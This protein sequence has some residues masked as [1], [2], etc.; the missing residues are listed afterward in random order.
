MRLTIHAGGIIRATL[1]A[2][3]IVAMSGSVSGA[4]F[5]P[6]RATNLKVLPNSIPMDSLVNMMGAFTRAL[7]RAMFALPRPE[8]RAG[9]RANGFFAR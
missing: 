4:Q 8:G 6:E 1:A 9:V 5:P 3:V 7:G 2:V